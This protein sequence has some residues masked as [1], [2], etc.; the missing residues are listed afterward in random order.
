MLNTATRITN[1]FNGD[2]F[3]DEETVSSQNLYGRLHLAVEAGNGYAQNRLIVLRC[4]REEADGVQLEEHTLREIWEEEGM[5]KDFV[6]PSNSKIMN[7]ILGNHL[8]LNLDP[9][10][11]GLRRAPSNTNRRW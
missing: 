5:V 3:F 8:L 10:P 6:R 2:S 9:V 4:P 7:T 1:V 11:L